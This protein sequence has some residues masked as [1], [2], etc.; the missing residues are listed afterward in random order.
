MTIESAAGIENVVGGALDDSLTGNVLSNRLVGGAGNDLLVGGLGDDSYAFDVDVALGS[1]AIIDQGG[2]DTLDFS[3]S[4]TN[5]I[6]IDL[7]LSGIQIVRSDRLL[8]TLGSDDALERVIGSSRNDRIS[9]NA[10]S[11]VLLGGS[12]DDILL[13]ANG[14]DVL[15]GGLGSDSL[16]G[17]EEEDLLIS[18]TTIFDSSQS[19]MLAIRNAWTAPEN[20]E[21]RTNRLR[22]GLD[23]VPAMTRVTAVK[24]DASTNVLLGGVGRDWFFANLT[25]GTLTD[26][27]SDLETNELVEEL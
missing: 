17:G 22:M 2:F 19:T 23:G 25:G 3:A 18:G 11:N 27:A 7:A 1:D 4:T 8:L 14:R 21:T 6:E 12:G 15:I 9:G 5:G 16:D 26:A 20:Y 10:A 13:G 24:R